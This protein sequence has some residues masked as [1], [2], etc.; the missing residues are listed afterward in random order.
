M[1]GM[2]LRIGKN[3]VLLL[4]SVTNQLPLTTR[5]LVT[6]AIARLLAMEE[7]PSRD[8]VLLADS[9]SPTR[10]QW[11]SG[12]C[13][14]LGCGQRVIRIPVP[15]WY[16]MG[17]GGAIVA[18]LTG[19]KLQPAKIVR[20]FCRSQ[21]YDADRSAKRLGMSFKLDWP[22]ELVRSFAGQ[23]RNFVLPPPPDARES[24]PGS[25][26]TFIGFGQV[27][28]QKHL[29]ALRRLKFAG[30]IAAFD[31]VAGTDAT[32]Q[33]VQSLDGATL[34]KSDLIVVASPGPFHS[35][36][37]TLL[38]QQDTPALI[39]KPLCYRNDELDAWMDL[40]NSRSSPISVCQN[41]RFKPHVERMLRHLTQYEPGK[42]LQ[43]DLSFHSPSVANESRPWSRNERA[44]RTLLMDY[45]IHFLDIACMFSTSGW[46]L[47][48]ARHELD[49]SG[50]TGL[51]EGRFNSDAYPVNFI[52]R[53]GLMP[54][55][56]TLR[57]TFQNYLADLSF[58]PDTFIA[59]MA[60]DG[61][62][63]YAMHRKAAFRAT[64]SKIWDKIRNRDSDPSHARAYLAAVKPV[65]PASSGIH[66]RSLY[67]FYKAVLELADAVYS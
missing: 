18:R 22:R 51:I 20:N 42:L 58:Y 3:N 25:R 67:S 46:S 59:Q 28:R 65:A 14:H 36:A 30:Q 9:D 35:Q 34:P 6:D 11:L 8:V 4:G 19:M 13:R 39:E 61:P 57:F 40:A 21:T 56:A 15:I 55:R 7:L 49:G 1:V 16:L 53:Q 52:L 50:A 10:Q 26:I 64:A 41:Y 45:A 54:R 33:S 12:C 44:A 2:G 29:P 27:V 5:E 31:V 62:A 23:E 66:V 47:Q 43:V 24:L 48:H 32:G 38:R 60:H 17:F 37:I 63:L